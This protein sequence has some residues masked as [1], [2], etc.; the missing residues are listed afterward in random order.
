MAT[1]AKEPVIDRFAAYLE[2]K[3]G[4]VGQIDI[5]AEH[6]I[7]SRQLEEDEAQELYANLLELGLT[8]KG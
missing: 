2:Q 6:V 4:K 8:R 7:F 3:Y 1:Q 5:L